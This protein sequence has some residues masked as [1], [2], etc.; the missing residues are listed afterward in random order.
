MSQTVPDW[1]L[2]TVFL[3]STVHTTVA[4]MNHRSSFLAHMRGLKFTISF[5]S[6]VANLGYCKRVFSEDMP[7]YFI[8]IIFH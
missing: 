3:K 7:Y 1:L 4:E 5:K 8:Q 2:D 6:W